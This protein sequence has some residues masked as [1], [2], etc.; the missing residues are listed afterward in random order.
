MFSISRVNR[1]F[2]T[3]AAIVFALGFVLVFMNPSHDVPPTPMPDSH[4][5]WETALKA[6]EKAPDFTLRDQDG[7]PF[8]LSLA[9]MDGPVVM[10]FFR[11]NWCP[12]CAAQLKKLDMDLEHYSRLGAQVVAISAQLPEDTA[13]TH[14]RFGIR[15]PVLS[16][17]GMAVTKLYGVEWTMPEEVR[18]KT[19]A[20]VQDAT[21]RTL[22]EINGDAGLTLPVPA[23]YV[24]AEDGTIA[25]AYADENYRERANS[26]VLQQALQALEDK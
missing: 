14:E 3:G 2:V 8:T 13:E 26:L 25:Y 5:T 16:D 18:E 6:G 4:V 15:M 12:I 11:G 24:I 17:T 19:D 22:A 10:T 7:N 21:D 20:Y 1:H 9:L 23:T